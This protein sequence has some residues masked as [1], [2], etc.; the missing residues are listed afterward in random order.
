M[1]LHKMNLPSLISFAVQLAIRSAML[2]VHIIFALATPPLNH[3]PIH[4]LSRINHVPI[5]ELSRTDHALSPVVPLA[6]SEVTGRIAGN[7]STSSTWLELL[8]ESSVS[9]WS[10]EETSIKDATT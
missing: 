9:S 3:V 10:L 5:H 1:F 4:E 6:G 8:A 7:A 2:A